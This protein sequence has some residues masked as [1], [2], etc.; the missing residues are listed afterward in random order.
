MRQVDDYAEYA[1]DVRARFEDPAGPP[2]FAGG[3]SLG[4]LLATHLV[5]RDQAQW[6]GLI[7][8]SAAIDLEWNLVTRSATPVLHGACCLVSTA[9]VT[10]RALSPSWYIMCWSCAAYSCIHSINPMRDRSWGSAEGTRLHF[11]GYRRPS[12]ASSHSWCRAGA[13]SRPCRW[14][15][16][17]TT[18]QWCVLHLVKSA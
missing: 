14:S 7:L 5:L 6:A 11:A 13:S 1:A 4:G 15:T 3:Q 2:A 18:L 8:C 12:G 10:L 17:A 16:S 9:T